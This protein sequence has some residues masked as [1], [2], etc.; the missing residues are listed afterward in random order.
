MRWRRL[1]ALLVAVAQV[2]LGVAPLLEV[3]QD[4][5]A[6]VHVEAYGTTFHQA[7]D[8]ANCAACAAQHLVGR[9]ERAPSL[10]TVTAQR[11][12]VTA[13]PARAFAPGLLHTAPSR[14][15]PFVV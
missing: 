6:G 13:A 15:P 7:H 9:V 4:A 11:W 1:A 2:A 8:D 14:A 12:A 10:A 5:S 3:R